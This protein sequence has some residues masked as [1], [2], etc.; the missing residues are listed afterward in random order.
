[1]S[2]LLALCFAALATVSFNIA[3]IAQTTVGSPPTNPP[4]Q[5]STPPQPILSTSQRAAIARDLIAKWQS[6][7]DSRPGGGGARWARILTKAVTAAS[8]ENVLRAT[9]ARS[10]DEV[11]I[12][13]TGGDIANPVPPEKKAIGNGSVAPQTLGSYSND[14]VYTPLPNGRCRIADSRVI[15]SPLVGTRGLYVEDVANYT[16]QGGTGTYSNGTGS[17]NC[18]INYYTPAY[19]VSV[20]LQSPTGAGVFKM[21]RYGIPYQTGNS[22]WVNAGSSGASADLIVEGCPGC[23]FE[24]GVYSSTSVHYVI[25]I[26]GYYMPPMRTPLSCYDTGA[27]VGQLSHGY[28]GGFS[29]PFCAAGYTRVSTNCFSSYAAVVLTQWTTGCVAYNF[30]GVTTNISASA[31]CCRVPGR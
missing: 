4:S 8:A 16:S 15:G 5:M 30:S 24:L 2:R 9:T 18:G 26:V 14:L 7:A 27:N 6:A 31:R 17:T 3:A 13:L 10:V 29:P 21:F 12:A 23:V 25:D 11:P 20:T 28:S 22:V 19:A 1:M